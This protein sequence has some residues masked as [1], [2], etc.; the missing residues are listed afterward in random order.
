[1]DKTPVSAGYSADGYII[2]QDRFTEQRYRTMPVSWNG[3]GPIA[4]YNLRRA[5]GQET[6]LREVCAELEALH[7]VNMPGP[8][9]MRA[10]R[11][12]LGKY[13]PA[14]RE[15]QG[16]EAALAAAAESYAGIF[17]YWEGREPHFI[18]YMRM[19]EGDFRFFNVSDGLEDCR[20]PMEQ[21]GREHLLG[22][23][24]AVFAL[25]ADASMVRL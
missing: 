12:Y 10:L 11:L 2:D 17:R 1:M 16:R 24:V 6:T 14:C 13:L 23:Y 4:A 20:M 9:S 25:N 15:S 5:A 21:F 7:R 19:P 3:C 8:T 22:G 18:S